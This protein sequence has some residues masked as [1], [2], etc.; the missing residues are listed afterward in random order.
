[1]AAAAPR[2]DHAAA[3]ISVAGGEEAPARPV[4]RGAP[5]AAPDDEPAAP[6]ARARRHR[7]ERRGAH[8]PGAHPERDG[9]LLARQQQQD[10]LV[11]HYH[12]HRVL[13]YPEG[14]RE[15]RGRRARGQQGAHRGQVRPHGT[16]GVK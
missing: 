11:Q 7:H 10:R 15:E 9:Q 4:P 8:R 5:A 12:H 1:V 6:E 14:Q 2:R 16:L 13:H 3:G